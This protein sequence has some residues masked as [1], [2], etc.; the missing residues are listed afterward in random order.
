[1]RQ[2]GER[3]MKTIRTSKH[4]I[5]HCDTVSGAVSYLL[6]N[7]AA[8]FQQSFYFVNPSM[9][10]D[11]RY[12]WFYCAFPPAGDANYGRTLAVIDFQEDEVRYFPE[13]QFL[14]ASPFVDLDT[15]EVYWCNKYGLFKRG[16]RWDSRT[17]CVAQLPPDLQ[18][19]GTVHRI[20]THL[21][22]SADGTEFAFDAE[23]GNRSYLGSVCIKTGEFRIWKSFDYCYNHAQFHPADPDLILFAQD[24]WNDK[25]T[26]KQ[27][28]IQTD[29]TGRRNRLWTIRRGEDPVLWKSEYADGAATHEWWSADGKSIYYVDGKYGAVRIDL[30][31]GAFSD[32]HPGGIWHAHSSAD[33]RYFAGDAQIT[34]DGRWYRGCAS[35]I[36]FYNRDTG[37]QI[38]IVSENPALYSPENPCVYH[39]DPHPQFL[40]ADNYIAFTTTVSGQ[41]TVG[42]SE[43]QDLVSLTQGEP[44]T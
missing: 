2:E 8:P 3:R 20:A 11:G 6:K 32:M 44:E 18:N 42:I 35:R 9:T 25:A 4:F 43:V 12:Y 28:G 40:A 29:E 37:R 21:T 22:R 36:N 34:E 38:D 19:K 10:R 24:Y 7:E 23:I 33:E 1:M 41:V 17:E 30:E 16:P 39:M 5:P 15:G 14:D 26:G 31:T 13:T 27:Y